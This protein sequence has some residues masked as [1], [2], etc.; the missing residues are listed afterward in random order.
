MADSGAAAIGEI[1]NGRYEI[2]DRLGGGAYF[3]VFRARDRTQNRLVAVKILRTDLRDLRQLRDR[4]CADAPAAL[5]LIHPNISRVYEVGRTRESAYLVTEYIRGVTLKERLSRAA[6]LTVAVAVDIGIAVAEALDFAHARGI[7]H[8]DVRSHHIHISDEGQVKVTD[9]GLNAILSASHAGGAPPLHITPY[10]A[11]EA[12]EGLPPTPASDLYSL[13]IVLFEMLTGALPFDGETAFAIALKVARDNAILPSRINA[14]VPTALDG[15]TLKCLQKDP[16]RRYRSAKALLNDLQQAQD[17]LRFG[18]PLNW[19]PSEKPDRAR[20]GESLGRRAPAPADV[21]IEE[22][23][24]AA[25]TVMSTLNRV[26]LALVGLGAFAVAFMIWNFFFRTVP[27]VRVPDVVGQSQTAALQRL[28]ELGLV[29]RVVEDSNKDTPQGEVFRTFPAAGKAVK[30]G[31]DISVWVSKGPE[32]VNVPDLTDMTTARAVDALREVGMKVGDVALEYNET[33]K[34]N[35]I[36]SQSPEPDKQELP[37]THVNLVKSQGPQ[38]V[39]TATPLPDTP[40]P[41]VVNPVP[42]ASTPTDS[43]PADIPAPDTSTGVKRRFQVAVNVPPGRD[44]QQIQIE[45]TDDTGSNIRYVGDHHPGES[46]SRTVS[47]SGDRVILRVYSDGQLLGEQV[48]SR[49]GTP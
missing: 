49:D 23:P 10:M 2:L 14:G 27:D 8:G 24:A 47:G 4:L 9:F 37:G 1:I 38:P 22:A 34:K 18:R 31:A 16:S 33:V 21:E 5:E 29:A 42:D 15:V 39:E 46:F 3:E 36:V 35:H 25:L 40:P 7:T 12:V 30:T 44:P 6:P 20:R 11:P 32:L 28:K 19:T 48:K 13:G 43:A 26:A 41:P 45:V 17:A